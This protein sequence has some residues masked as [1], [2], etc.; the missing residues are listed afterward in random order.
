LS[1]AIDNSDLTESDRREKREFIRKKT[2]LNSTASF[3]WKRE[4]EREKEKE[5]KRKREGETERVREGLNLF[6]SKY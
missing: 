6:N 3:L 1:V 5:R 4:R 2:Y